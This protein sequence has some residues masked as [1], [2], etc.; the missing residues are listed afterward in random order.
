M[1]FQLIQLTTL[2]I[3]VMSLVYMAQTQDVYGHDPS[4]H[5]PEFYVDCTYGVYDGTEQTSNN[6]DPRAYTDY[7]DSSGNGT[8]SAS[9]WYL[10]YYASGVI[11][12]NHTRYGVN[13]RSHGVERDR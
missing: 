1:K 13:R 8:A 9:S 5:P 4:N 3:F 10:R 6:Q 11:N 2:I 7:S 12:G